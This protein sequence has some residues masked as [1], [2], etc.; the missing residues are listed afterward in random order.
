MGERHS[1]SRIEYAALVRKT[2][3][4]DKFRQYGKV[5]EVST[6]AGV[7]GTPRKEEL[8]ESIN[9]ILK[10]NKKMIKRLLK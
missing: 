7:A 9:S 6:A 1:D 4:S 3:N 5:D 8:Q 10:E 2:L